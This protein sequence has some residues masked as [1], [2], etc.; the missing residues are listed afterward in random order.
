M[1]KDDGRVISNFIN[2]ALENKPITIYGN[3]LQTRSFCYIDDMIDALI[4]MMETKK[5]ITGPIN[6]G[7]PEEYTMLELA[8]KVKELTQSESEIVFEKLP[9]DDPKQ[10]CP[11]ISKAKELLGWTPKVNLDVGLY[12]TKN[13]FKIFT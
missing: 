4:L 12:K 10:R 3:G 9:E 11:N 1:R 13:Y 8:T 5:E 7:N 2:Q 6:L